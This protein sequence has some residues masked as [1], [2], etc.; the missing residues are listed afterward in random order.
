MP[1]KP[2]D[3]A[4]NEAFAARSRTLLILTERVRCTKAHLLV[5]RAEL[6]SSLSLLTQK[7]IRAQ[8]NLQNVLSE[9][10][11]QKDALQHSHR[12]KIAQINRNFLQSH[13]ELSKQTENALRYKYTPFNLSHES[14]PDQIQALLSQIQFT[15]SRIPLPNQ[16][17]YIHPARSLSSS[18]QRCEAILLRLQTLSLETE[19]KNEKLRRLTQ[20]IERKTA[21]MKRKFGRE[22]QKYEE[23]SRKL[24]DREAQF[25]NAIEEEFRGILQ[26]HSDAEEAIEGSAVAQYRR[27]K[28]SV[29]ELRKVRIDLQELKD[30]ML[31]YPTVALEAKVRVARII[32][33]NMKQ[34]NENLR[35]MVERLGSVEG[36]K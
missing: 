24:S 36:S 28:G 14:A 1:V 35:R 19:T 3:F 31:R 15:Y 18:T 32:R 16:E 25:A 9:F 34:E 11:S 33:D 5:R 13:T 8:R 26:K 22:E 27:A 12:E 20:R 6:N 29:K 4:L 21:R 23:G 2:S 30:P 7:R 10:Q 17:P